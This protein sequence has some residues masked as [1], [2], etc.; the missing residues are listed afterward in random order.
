M[1]K[2]RNKKDFFE[3]YQTYIIAT[4]VLLFSYY[5]ITSGLIKFDVSNYF[6]FQNPQ[7]P[8]EP[9]KELLTYD[10]SIDL[11]PNPLCTGNNLTGTISS[12]IPNGVCSIFVN[13][14]EGFRLF[15]NV[16]LDSAGDF[17]QTEPLLVAGTAVFRV[18]CCD[19]QG[20][21]RVSNDETLV[22]TNAIPPCELAPGPDSDGDGFSD[23]EENAADTNPNDPNDYPGHSGLESCTAICGA[24]GFV[25][26]RTVNS[27]TDCVGTEVFEVSGSTNCCCTPNSGGNGQ[28]VNTCDGTIVPNGTPDAGAFCDSLHCLNFYQCCDNYWNST[29]QQMKCGCVATFWCQENFWYNLNPGQCVCPPHTWKDS[30]AAQ[31]RC[32]PIQ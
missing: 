1:A 19:R 9:E 21:C 18:V 6:N 13:A 8:L 7:V 22:S 11:N 3:K 16:N 31:F 24:K 23:D 10:L 30:E 2:K 32:V 4:A 5:A 14:G 26:G 12:N 17:S 28:E 29:L 15:A 27:V 25:S 20:N